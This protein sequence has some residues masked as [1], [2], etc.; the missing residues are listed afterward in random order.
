M[1]PL[2]QNT[3]DS[4][5]TV[6]AQPKLALTRIRKFAIPA[7]PLPEQVAIAAVLTDMD[8]ELAL[9]EQRLAKTRD[10]KQGMMQELLTGRTRLT[11]ANRAIFAAAGI[12]KLRQNF[13]FI[14]QGDSTYLQPD[15]KMIYQ[16]WLNNMLIL[17]T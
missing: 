9:L 6:G 15:L 14:K 7:P 13:D 12:E 3:I 8:A 10:L 17:L 5:Q 11:W 16:A 4:I 1:S 2:I